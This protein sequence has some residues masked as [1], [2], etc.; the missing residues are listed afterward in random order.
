MGADDTSLDIEINLKANTAGG[1]QATAAI[2][3]VTDAQKKLQAIF[4]STKNLPPPPKPPGADPKDNQQ[5]EQHNKHLH[6]MHRLFHGLNEVV[7]GLGFAMQAAFS[8]IGASIGAGLAVLRVFNE[9]IKAMDEA[10]KKTLEEAAK[11]LTHTLEAQRE[12]LIHAATA[13]QEFKDRL[14]DAARTQQTVKEQT[15]AAIA[16]LKAQT[17]EQISLEDAL[18]SEDA[19]ALEWRHKAGLVSDADYYRQ[20]LELEEQY[21]ERK[22]AI[23]DRD[24][25]AEILLQKAGIEQTKAKQPELEIAAKEARAKADAS[26][27]TL[28]GMDTPQQ[29]AAGVKE[30]RAQLAEFRRQNELFVQIF[31]K[32]Q[33]AA[34]GYNPKTFESYTRLL[35]AAKP[36]TDLKKYAEQY[37]A[38]QAQSEHDKR[39]ADRKER[40]A[41]ENARYGTEQERAWNVAE[42]RYELRKRT[43]AEE[44]RM[45]RETVAYREATESPVGQMISL[46]AAGES[47]IQHGQRA[48]AAQ[49]SAMQQLNVLLQRRGDN[50]EVILDILG[51][52]VGHDD[53]LFAKIA[54]LEA[55]LTNTYRGAILP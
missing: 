25:K 20:K 2:N 34:A 19:A 30:A 46:A 21:A 11:P 16:A 32:D 54:Q 27:T 18:K 22:R 7:P 50:G 13:A 40:E 38:R 10:T 42:D 45:G 49:L 17:A 39:E 6:E 41:E 24:A 53:Q 47:A 44:N 29:M 12:A 15:E 35:R 3:Q 33:Q 1:P 52:L 5:L 4:N 55:R 48:S 51:R 8:P 31:E 43:H 36:E 14:A 26:V 28:A 23:E 9:H 37:G